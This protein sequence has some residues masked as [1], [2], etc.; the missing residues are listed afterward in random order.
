NAVEILRAA[1]RPVMLVGRV[2][3]GEAGWRQRILL[4]ETLG[5]RVITDLK[6]GAGFPTDHFL[7]VGA[8]GIFAGP[9]A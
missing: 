9:A 5:L 2:G 8:P 7:H 1:E 3:R 6:V 4:A